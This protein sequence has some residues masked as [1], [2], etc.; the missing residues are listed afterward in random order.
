MKLS[1]GGWINGKTA[2]GFV[3]GV[4]L[5]RY[6]ARPKE[7]QVMQIKA[8]PGLLSIKRNDD[9]L[10]IVERDGA[11]LA[12]KQF[13][14]E[15]AAYEEEMRNLDKAI[16][17]VQ[18]FSPTLDIGMTMVSR[19]CELILKGIHEVEATQKDHEDYETMKK[20]VSKI[21]AVAQVLRAP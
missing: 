10:W 13:D 3:G 4:C 16:Q 15:V 18:G 8:S 17:Q 6:L 2:V 14:E 5:G 11:F 19:S 7:Q 1:M 21:D 20:V 12:T 9:G